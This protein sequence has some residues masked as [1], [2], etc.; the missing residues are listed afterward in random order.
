LAGV[1]F[2]WGQ[3]RTNAWAESA[4]AGPAGADEALAELV[5]GNKRYVTG[6]NTHHDFGPE[7]SAL[8]QS[9]HPFA[10]ILGCADSRVSPELAFDQT[11]G[12]LFVVSVAGNF[13]DENRLASIEFG[14]SVLGASLIMVLG[15][16]QCGA[17]KGAIDVYT[18]NAQLPGHL[19]GL[20][21]HLKAPVEKALNEQ[22]SL[23]EN[24]I[25]ENILLNV[26]ALRN[27]KPVLAD[28]VKENRLRVVGGLYELAT[29]RVEVL[30]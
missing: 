4:A 29:G 22:G 11:R 14:A 28:M 21:A 5:A 10:I 15:H 26:E 27:S 6:Q 24:A 1:T 19:P 3:L 23:L 20:V 30:T 2:A 8:A 13:I 18:K 17:I 12:R 9:Q 25:R 16:D 7:R